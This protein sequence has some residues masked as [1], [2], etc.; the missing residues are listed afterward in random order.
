MIV[1][2][3]ERPMFVADGVIVRKRATRT[4]RVVVAGLGDVFR[5]DD[6][7]GVHAVRRLGDQLYRGIRSIEVGTAVLNWQR[8]IE[9]AE[10]LLVILAM[11]SGRAP[12]TIYRCSASGLQEACRSSLS[13]AAFLSAI[14]QMRKAPAEI[15]CL[16][17]EPKQ[18]DI[19]RQLSPE[20]N[21][22]LDD[23]VGLA[24]QICNRWVD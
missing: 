21:Q 9:G 3:Q 4:P 16:C 2:M 5:Q 12:G 22:C 1:S 15:V 8:P 19:G 10:R 17:V 14:P 11:E 7:V 20:V 24:S 6:G 23:L 18:V 13:K